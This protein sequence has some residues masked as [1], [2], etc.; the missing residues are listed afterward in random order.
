MELMEF[1]YRVMEELSEASVPIIFKGA[2]VLNLVVQENNPSKVERLTKDID[3]DWVGDGPTMEQMLDKLQEAVNRVDA[4]LHVEV[5][6]E[7][8]EK[9]SAGFK[10][11]NDDG[12]KIASIDLS[13]RKNEFSYPYISYVNNVSITGASL[14]KMLSDKLYA[15]SGKGVCRRVKDLVDIYV[16]SYITECSVQKLLDIWEQTGRIIGDFSEFRNN[17]PDIAQA[18]EKMVGIKNK[19]DFVALY[20]RVSEFIYPFMNLER[21]MN[22]EWKKDG[23]RGI[24][25]D[26][27]DRDKGRCR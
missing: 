7:F 2:M 10:I 22:A 17:M 8:A 26:I 3:G 18:Y 1:L 16:M 21:S 25:P 5:Y 4:T 14:D 24:A 23:W 15:V 13:V 20:T 9:K 19:P 11:V 12:E 27:Y 6:R